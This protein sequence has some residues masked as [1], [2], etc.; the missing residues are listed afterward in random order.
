MKKLF[1]LVAILAMVGFTSSAFATASITTQTV[2]GGGNFTPSTRVGFSVTSTAQS[3][4][5]ASAHLNGT[6]QYGTGGGSAFTGY[7]A[8]KIYKADIPTQASDATVGVPTS[9]TDATTLEG[10]GWQ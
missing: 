6:F 5:A 4:A 2:I 10:T 7:D 3:Y 1:I 8:S 9:Q